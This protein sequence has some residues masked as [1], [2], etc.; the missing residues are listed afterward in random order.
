MV[1]LSEGHQ[2]KST[3]KV[4]ALATVILFG[5]P[6]AA[7][8]TTYDAA[9]A[10]EAGWTSSSNPNGVWSYGYSSSPG[11]AVTLYTTQVP[12]ADSPTQ[13]QMWIA[14]AVNCCTA[15]PSVG[16]NNG[17]AFDDGNVAQ[18]ANQILLVSAVSGQP[19]QNLVT[20]LL[21]TAPVTGTYSLTSTFFG[22]QRGM[23]V[24]V[25]VLVNST[26]LFSSFVTSFGQAVPFD[27]TLNL[28]AG[29]TVTF[30][31]TDNGG[32]Q[33]TGL[34][35]S[36]TITPLPAALPLFA[37]GLGGLGLLGWRRRRKALAA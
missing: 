7:N 17:P 37:T 3:T 28:T 15:S 19:N 2:M 31:V 8:A 32:A 10:F 27:T 4:W 13:Q 33:N 36:L 6:A 20:D 11:G 34:D 18:L 26:V 1:I 30:A 16:F 35:A 14:P 21:F 9:A 24:G 12:G 5:A 29:D 25:D 22:D 23:N